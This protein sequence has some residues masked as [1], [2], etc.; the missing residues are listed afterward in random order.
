[1]AINNIM[2]LNIIFILVGLIVACSTDNSC[3]VADSVSLIKE[4]NIKNNK[5][6]IYSRVS[7]FQ[8]KEVFYEMFSNKPVF[9]QCGQTK[10]P[11]VSDVHIDSSSGAAVKLIVQDKILD[12][13]YSKDAVERSEYNN[14]EIEVTQ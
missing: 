6:Y 13:V 5:Y 1:M 4:I 3:A 14:I 12:I 7:G 9:D 11:S 2:K 10:I 8:E